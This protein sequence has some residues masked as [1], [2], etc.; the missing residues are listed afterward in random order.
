MVRTRSCISLLYAHAKGPPGSS[1]RAFDLRAA[2]G[3]RTRDPFI[4]SEVLWPTELR[5]HAANGCQEST[6]A[7]GYFAP[8]NPPYPDVPAS[9]IETMENSVKH[10]APSPTSTRAGAKKE[11][12]ETSASKGRARRRQASAV[13]CGWR[14]G[15]TGA[16]QGQEQGLG[17]DAVADQAQPDED[18][19]GLDAVG[20][21][22]GGEDVDAEEDVDGPLAMTSRLQR[23]RSGSSKALRTWRTMPAT[24]AIRLAQMAV[25]PKTTWPA[26]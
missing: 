26:V 20:L 3:I 18:A 25:R 5:R 6:G 7:T 9:R 23:K 1:G 11:A 10:T 19:A 2:F 8:D 21:V 24:R 16:D 4:T 14:A 17:Q 12:S 22:G 15:G 13:G